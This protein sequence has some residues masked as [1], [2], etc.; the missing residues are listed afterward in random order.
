MLALGLPSGPIPAVMIAAMM[1][2]GISPGPLLISQ[3]PELFW[4]FIASMYVGNVVLLI[5]NLPLV[6]IFVNVLRVPYPLLYPAILLFCVL[7]VYAVNG[8]TVDIGIMCAMG[9]LGYLLRKF[10]F[11][12]APVVLGLILA[13]M[14]EMAFRQSLAMSSGSYAIFVNRPIAAV[15]LLLGLAL[16][17]LSLVPFLVKSVDWR[18]R[19]GVDA[20]GQGEKL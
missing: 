5:L 13:P 1:V 15:M 4:G 7:G 12:T 8:S 14:L 9:A 2:H 3:Q 20:A 17:L 18:Q 11:E 19:L 16:L 10:D 6:G